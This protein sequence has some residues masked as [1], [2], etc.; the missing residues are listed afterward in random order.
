MKLTDEQLLDFDVSRIATYR[1]GQGDRLLAEHG[2]LYRSQLLIARWI[3]GWRERAGARHEQV[4]DSSA[5]SDD[6]EA[7]W[8]AALRDIAAH[9]RSGDLV[10][11]GVL[12]DDEV[13]RG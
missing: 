12:H 13:G 7:G 10:P 1:P 9:L 4:G 3:D 8:D 11:G 6:W 2:D 5:M